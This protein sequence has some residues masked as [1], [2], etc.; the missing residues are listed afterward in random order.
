MKKMMIGLCFISFLLVPNILVA[1]ELLKT[2]PFYLKIETEIL[3]PF[4]NA[5]KDG[6]VEALKQYISKD[7]Y[8]KNRRLLDQN[9]KYPEF[10]R[11]YYQGTS[12]H[13]K[14]MVLEGDTIT[15]DVGIEKPGGS[16]LAEELHLVRVQQGPDSKI[17]IQRQWRIKE[18]RENKIRRM[19][20]K[21][22]YIE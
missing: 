17:P 1:E 9:R 19:P 2:D 8:R 21:K 6:N 22:L 18:L 16:S 7:M 4:F 11:K 5:L 13:T 12:F 10:L 3:L 20:N 15:V 14:S